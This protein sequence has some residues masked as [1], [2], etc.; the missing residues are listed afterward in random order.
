VLDTNPHGVDLATCSGLDHLDEVPGF[1][2]LAVEE[3]V[4]DD[5]LLL[6]VVVV[7]QEVADLTRRCLVLVAVP[8]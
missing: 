1:L 5:A 7:V 4:H 3:D 8:Q 6:W 2:R